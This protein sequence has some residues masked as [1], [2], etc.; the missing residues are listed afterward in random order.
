[1]LLFKARTDHGVDRTLAKYS[2]TDVLEPC[3]N[4]ID[5]ALAISTVNSFTLYTL[6]K[7]HYTCGYLP[8]NTMK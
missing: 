5:M 8:E 6:E 2:N 7:M 1:M 4:V 3:N